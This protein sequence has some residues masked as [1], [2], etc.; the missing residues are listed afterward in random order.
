MGFWADPALVPL[1][2]YSLLSPGTMPV[3][4]LLLLV[5]VRQDQGSKWLYCSNYW[6]CQWGSNPL[7][8][9]LKWILFARILT[10]KWEVGRCWCALDLLSANRRTM[11]F[12]IIE[13][14]T[15]FANWTLKILIRSY[16]KKYRLPV[17]IVSCNAAEILLCVP[18]YEMIIRITSA[19]KDEKENIACQ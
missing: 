5:L 7:C 8:E 19:W 14:S 13:W 6:N 10:T 12:L 11:H 1:T 15:Q 2:S 18:E 9:A 16:S 17:G 3:V 4:T